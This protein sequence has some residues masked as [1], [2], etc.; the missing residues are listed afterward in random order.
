[1]QYVFKDDIKV[2]EYHGI[3]MIGNTDNSILIGL[4]DEGSELVSAILKNLDI[5]DVTENQRVLL[6]ELEQSGFFDREGNEEVDMAYFHITSRC[7]LHCVGCYSYETDRNSK[8]DLSTK[9]CCSVL[10]KLR[11]AGVRQVIISGGEPLLRTDLA[12]IL[13]YARETCQFESIQVVSN[14]MVDRSRYADIL[15]YIDALSISVDGYDDNISYIRDSN[16]THVLDIVRYVSQSSSK[17]NMIYTIHKQ[18]LDMLDKYINL[19]V[20]M[21]VPFS[22]SL[23]TVR[24]DP[25]F[26]DFILKADDYEYLSR[27]VGQMPIP[28]NDTPYN[29]SLGCRA[30]CGIGKSIISIESNADIYPCHMLH[31]EELR[32]GNAIEDDILPSIKKGTIWSVDN[33]SE[34]ADCECRYLC[35]GGCYARRYLNCSNI[36]QSKD[37][38]CNL[39]KAGINEVCKSI[40]LI[41]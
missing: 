8:P 3:K 22:F 24:Q 41:T 40:L 37:P 9:Q 2:F 12:E 14:G 10:S 15:P 35:G 11:Q 6:D 32:L 28:I 26:D 21:K 5:E 38:C 39:Y 31:E 4:D 13:K 33:I 18:N 19:S 34:C 30:S 27:L 23:L 1:M 7:N 16:M 17:L 25:V 36:E 29:Q 20:R